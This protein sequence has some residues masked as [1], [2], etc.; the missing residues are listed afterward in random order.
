MRR[1]ITLHPMVSLKTS[2]RK[3]DKARDPGTGHVQVDRQDVSYS[4]K[5]IGGREDDPALSQLSG[6]GGQL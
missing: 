4:Y 2:R 6:V 3:K 1:H 5:H